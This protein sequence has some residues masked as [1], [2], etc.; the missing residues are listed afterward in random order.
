MHG[1]PSVVLG[2]SQFEQYFDVMFVSSRAA[3]FLDSPV[4]DKVLRTHNSKGTA[5]VAVETGKFIVPL[6]KNAKTEFLKRETEYCD[7]HHWSR[8]RGKSICHIVVYCA[9]ED[10]R[11]MIFLPTIIQLLLFPV[12]AGMMTTN[13]MMLFSSLK[14]QA[15][16]HEVIAVA[17]LIPV[18]ADESRS[19]VDT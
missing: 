12:V 7:K 14:V 5:L 19:L 9:F 6:L 10:A 16:R 3:K 2:K 8:M 1:D 15:V 13:M 11:R 17:S 18:V 4:A